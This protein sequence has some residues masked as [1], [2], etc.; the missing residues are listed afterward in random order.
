MPRGNSPANPDP[1]D[2]CAVD[3]SVTQKR[4]LRR[5]PGAP[6]MPADLK[7]SVAEATKRMGR[8]PPS[9]GV[10]IEKIGHR[11]EHTSPHTDLAA[12]EV[13]ICDAFGTRSWSTMRVFLRQLTALCALHLDEAGS[14]MPS[15]VE[16]NAALNIVNGVRPRNEIE[17]AMAAQMVAVHFMTMK[18]SAYAISHSWDHRTTAIAGKLARTFVMQADGLQRLKGRRQTAKQV[19]NVNKTEIHEHRTVV[20]ATPGGVEN[21]GQVHGAA[22]SG[23]VAGS[24]RPALV[25]SSALP[26]EEERRRPVQV[27]GREG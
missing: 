7:R 6:P 22:G 13:Q 11:V 2:T 8:R 16:L 19:I 20:M 18:V 15:E 14:W 9:P 12:W 25:G 21:G 4:R 17:A 26:G 10:Q 23:R 24:A 27:A 1:I 5:R 3:V